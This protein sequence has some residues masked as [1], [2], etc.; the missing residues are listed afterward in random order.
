MSR[1]GRWG[2]RSQQQIG[3]EKV[4]RGKGY[5]PVNVLPIG[6]GNLLRWREEILDNPNK[7]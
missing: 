5:R 6:R 4:Q 7:E 1:K 3:R 2:G